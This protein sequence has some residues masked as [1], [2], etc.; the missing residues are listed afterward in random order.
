LGNYEIT[1]IEISGKKVT[2]EYT[3]FQTGAGHTQR[4]YVRYKNSK[5]GRTINFMEISEDNPSATTRQCAK[6]L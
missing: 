3:F 1:G 5:K 4:K 6:L 2:G